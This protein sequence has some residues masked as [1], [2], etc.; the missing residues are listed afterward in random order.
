MNEKHPKIVIVDDEPNDWFL[1][2]FVGRL[3]RSGFAIAVLEAN[4]NSEAMLQRVE[5]EQPKLVIT[6]L[7]WGNK[8][9][10]EGI[11]LFRALADAQIPS[12]LYSS[13][14]HVVEEYSHNEGQAIHSK[15]DPM[16]IV[17]ATINRLLSEQ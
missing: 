10:E 12:I 13:N 17:I 11:L 14:P 3:Q 5:D 1:K 16:E 7:N 9:G 15:G 4:V 6:D 8:L 2:I